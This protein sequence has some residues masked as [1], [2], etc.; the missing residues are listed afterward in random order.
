MTRQDLLNLGNSRA[1]V[2]VD[3]ETTGFYPDAGDEIIELAA[4]KLINRQVVDT[5]HAFISPSRS[6][7]ADAIAVHGLDDFFLKKHGEEA[8]VIF[9][10]FARFIEEAMLVGHNIRRFDYYFLTA[11]FAR[12]NLPR[13]ANDILDTLE[14][15]RAILSLPNYKLATVAAH[16][17][18]S[19]TGAHRAM[20][21]V[22]MTREILLRLWPKRF[23]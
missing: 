16:F 20:A 17:D 2:V 15:A 7:P 22:V 21:D 23:P 18:I 1:L 11:H 6:V 13:P 4:E 10:R 14:L 9:P 3:V 19:T 12:L 5:F 8:A